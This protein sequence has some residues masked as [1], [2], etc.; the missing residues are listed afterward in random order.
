MKLTVRLACAALAACL[1]VASAHA[2][3]DKAVAD[4]EELLKRVKARFDVG[5]V[6]RTDVAQTEW[7]LLNMKYL[8][9]QL[10]KRDYCEQGLPVL[11]LEG[12]GLEEEAKVGQRTTHDIIEHKREYFAFKKLCE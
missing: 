3:S 5:E 4:A 10:A 8:A 6:T 7:H 11:E 1:L 2:Y 12:Q 9:G